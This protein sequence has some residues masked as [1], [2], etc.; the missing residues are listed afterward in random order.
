MTRSFHLLTALSVFFFL[1]TEAIAGITP[2]TTLPSMARIP[3]SGSPGQ[4]TNVP[5]S[6]PVT[7][8]HFSGV[9]GRMG[10]TEK[11]DYGIITV[12]P[13][14]PVTFGGTNYEES[15]VIR[16][17]NWTYAGY[18]GGGALDYSQNCHGYAFGVGDWPD[19]STGIIGSG[20]TACWVPDGSN[21]TIADR[22]THTVRISMK[23]CKNSL[24]VIVNESSE[25]FRESGIYT[26]TGSCDVMAGGGVDLG[27]GNGVR[28]NLTFTP[29]KKK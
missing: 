11:Y 18:S 2:I 10:C 13:V 1:S 7:G 16:Y 29:Y 20:T 28:A 8:N 22:V 19:S 15:D 12:P 21:A 5:I 25:K 6:V 23:D 24:G 4:Y 26:Q 27:L 3:V 17:W 9:Q 14:W